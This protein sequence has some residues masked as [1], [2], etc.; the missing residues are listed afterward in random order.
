[1]APHRP[2][3]ARAC[4][5]ASLPCVGGVSL[6]SGGRVATAHGKQLGTLEA[7]AESGAG[8]AAQSSRS[9]RAAGLLS[10]CVIVPSWGQPEE[11]PG[12]PNLALEEPAGRGGEE[13][14]ASVICGAC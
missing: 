4:L 8:F 6:L 2:P 7:A 14:P 11:N 10:P 12:E 5:P 13:M 9:G 3:R 1:M